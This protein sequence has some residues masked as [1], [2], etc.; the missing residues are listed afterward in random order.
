MSNVRQLTPELAKQAE[1]ELNE[2]PS[3]TAEDLKTLREWIVKQ[4]HLTAKLGEDN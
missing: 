3:R 4:P 1:G 2:V